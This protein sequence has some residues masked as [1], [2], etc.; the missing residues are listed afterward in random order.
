M[1]DEEYVE[2]GAQLDIDARFPVR[3]GTNLKPAVY[4]SFESDIHGVSKSLDTGNFTSIF[5]SPNPE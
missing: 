2:T 5:P 1:S 3:P 4:P